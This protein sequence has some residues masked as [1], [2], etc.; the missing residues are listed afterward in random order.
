[1][2]ITPLNRWIE[3]K[4]GFSPNDRAAMER[5]KLE[6][7]R[8]VVGYARARSPFYAKLYGTLPLPESPADFARYPTIGER[9]V[10]DSGIH[11]LCV[12]VSEVSRIITMYTSGTTDNPKRLFF[13]EG[14]IA[15]TLDFFR[16]GMQTLCVPGDRALVLFP[17]R[18]TDSVGALL[19]TALEDIGAGVFLADRD[20]GD[21]TAGRERVTI[22]CGP[23]EYLAHASEHSRGLKVRAVL[24][25]SD[26]LRPGHRRALE[27]NWGC[28]VF[29]HYGTTE[30]GLGGAVECGAHEGMHIRENDLYYELGA[31][32]ELIMTTLTRTGMPLIRYRTGDTGRLLTE[33]CRCGSALFRIDCV[34]RI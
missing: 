2:K 5:F 21:E 15:L 27:E 31:S 9:D 13:T 32:G 17:A 6:R 28:E 19:K 14:D 10:A 12:P 24:T 25:S 23:P 8:T 7:I 16:H 11:M 18:V 20:T 26:L 1:M 30:T 3:E 33:P 4:H 29:D 34:R 22:A